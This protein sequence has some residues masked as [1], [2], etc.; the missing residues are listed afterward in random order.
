LV[1]SVRAVL[2]LADGG[3]GL[4]PE[5]FEFSNAAALEFATQGC[6]DPGEAIEE[7]AIRAG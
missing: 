6:F 5:A 7:A 1:V 2:L 3:F 4:L